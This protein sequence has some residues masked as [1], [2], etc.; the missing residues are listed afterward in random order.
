MKLEGDGLEDSKQHGQAASLATLGLGGLR[1][2]QKGGGLSSHTCTCSDFFAP[3]AGRSCARGGSCCLPSLAEARERPGLDGVLG[4]R[5]RRGLCLATATAGGTPSLPALLATSTATV[6]PSTATA[7]ASPA[8]RPIASS[9][10]A[11]SAIAPAVLPP[12][13]ATATASPATVT[14]TTTALLPPT[15]R[16]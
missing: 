12:S 3:F 1:L 5:R 9:P 4:C 10:P 15:T 16:P 6:A 11:P 14:A 8:A 7:P 13:T 2:W